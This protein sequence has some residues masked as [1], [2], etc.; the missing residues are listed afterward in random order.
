MGQDF[1]LRKT[2]RKYPN[3]RQQRFIQAFLHGPLQ[4]RYNA[5]RAARAAGYFWPGKQGPRLM[6][7]PYILNQIELGFQVQLARA[8]SGLEREQTCWNCGAN[9]LVDPRKHV[10]KHTEIRRNVEPVD[11]HVRVEIREAAEDLDVLSQLVRMM[12]QGRF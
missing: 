5:T 4:D 3:E 8:R 10:G 7:Y 11:D 12:K 2:M 1:Q 6:T 9:M